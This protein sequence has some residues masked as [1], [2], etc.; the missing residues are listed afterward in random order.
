MVKRILCFICVLALCFTLFAI[1]VFA[2]TSEQNPQYYSVVKGSWLTADGFGYST[3]TTATPN[4]T[5]KVDYNFGGN[6]LGN[7]FDLDIDYLVY[8]GR[9]GNGFN[10]YS[11]YQNIHQESGSSRYS[12]SYVPRNVA[13]IADTTAE[14]VISLE[15]NF[16]FK[17]DRFTE[18]DYET[19]HPDFYTGANE[20]YYESLCT[21]V[22]VTKDAQDIPL[23]IS[24]DAL[25]RSSKYSEQDNGA[26]ITTTYDTISEEFHQVVYG[27]AYVPTIEERPALQA[28]GRI[29]DNND[30]DVAYVACKALRK[31]TADMAV[32][33]G[34]TVVDMTVHVDIPVGASWYGNNSNTDLELI[35]EFYVGL[36]TYG[37]EDVIKEIVDFHSD[38]EMS[39][40][41]H[42]E[43][44]VDVGEVGFNGILNGIGGFFGT[45]IAPGITLG[46]VIAI[47]LAV[48]ITFVVL[49]FF[50]GG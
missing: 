9:L 16:P 22:H 30:V 15:F 50:A 7:G 27:G 39:Y 23:T 44:Y 46:G 4:T 35:D 41:N 40:Q 17:L 20:S 34:S 5:T 45:S 47:A 13:T 42:K 1:S 3:S 21:F 37:N 11:T 26:T 28:G 12:V 10:E 33:W 49:R 36:M 31:S 38:N 43:Y 14:Y 24:Y 18:N 25:L 19:F 29:F 2:D 48:L 6:V 8:N 32:D